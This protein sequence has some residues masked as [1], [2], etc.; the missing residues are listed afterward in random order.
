MATRPPEELAST[1]MELAWRVA[2]LKAQQQ[3]D[4]IQF[5]W[6]K[7]DHWDAALHDLDRAETALR[8]LEKIYRSL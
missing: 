1:A 4:Q 6:L 8:A 7:G 2:Q 5:P 3:R